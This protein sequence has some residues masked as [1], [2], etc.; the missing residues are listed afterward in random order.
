MSSIYSDPPFTRGGTLLAYG[1]ATLDESSNPIEGGDIVGQIKVFRDENPTTGQVLSAR[2]VYCLAVRVKQT[3]VANGQP[4]TNVTAGTVVKL[5][6]GSL[7][8]LDGTAKAAS[9]DTATIAGQVGVV[10]E[11]LT[12]TPLV[13]DV[14]WV[15]VKGP[16]SPIAVSSAI[17]A[18]TALD[19]SSSAGSVAAANTPTLGES[20]LG[21]ALANKGVGAGP[22]RTVVTNS[23]IA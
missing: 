4:A 5:A 20:F 2:L 21:V 16:T 6:A 8:D 23:A 22:V 17:T 13:N 18:G 9:T 11:Y 3:G 15:V 10:D 7:S 19:V 1:T 14:I 12:K